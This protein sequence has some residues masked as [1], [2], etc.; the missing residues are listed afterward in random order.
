MKRIDT[1]TLIER[2]RE[3]FAR[4]G[5]PKKI[6]TDNGRQFV[7][8][9]FMEFC[10]RNKIKFM[11]PSPYHPSSNGA[12]ENAVKA[13]KQGILKASNDVRNDS[14]S[15]NTIIQRYLLMYRNNPHSETG[16]SPA[17][18][19]FGRTLRTPLDI[20]RRE[21]PEKG[22]STKFWRGHRDVR[23]Q[24]KERAYARCYRNPN[25]VVW[26][27]VEIVEVLGD[28]T[29]LVKVEGEETI[30]KRHTDQLIKTGD[31]KVGNE[32]VGNSNEV[33]NEIRDPV[34]VLRELGFPKG[35]EGTTKEVQVTNREKR[36]PRKQVP[37]ESAR[38]RPKRNIKPPERLNL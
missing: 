25:K 18:L 28:R 32:D 13:V 34:D 27:P 35:Q 26:R 17:E 14:V 15:L 6:V 1:T 11:T 8:E 7:S 2:L 12:A 23:F 4:F 9:E 3:V 24:E 10:T 37:E 29:Y 30:W 5:L 21:K 16:K 31:Y 22:D 38:S 33:T 20:L 36:V 19:M